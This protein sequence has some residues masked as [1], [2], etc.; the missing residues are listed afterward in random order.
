VHGVLLPNDKE[1]DCL[2]AMIDG[3]PEAALEHQVP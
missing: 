3:A 2:D 1:H